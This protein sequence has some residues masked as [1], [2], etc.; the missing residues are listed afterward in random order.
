MSDKKVVQKV[1]STLKYEE[2]AAELDQIIEQ[3]EEGNLSLEDTLVLY[4]RGQALSKH[5]AELLDQAELKIRTLAGD[6]PSGYQTQ[7]E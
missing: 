7:E 1:V 2:A 3:L 6:T 4:E 5:C